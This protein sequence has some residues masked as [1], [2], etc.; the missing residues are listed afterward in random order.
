MD[1]MLLREVEYKY[2]QTSLGTWRSYLYPTGQLFREFQS[3]RRVYGFPLIHY[4]RGICPETGRHVITRG[5]IAVGRLAV[6]GIAIGHA[7]LG[8]VAIG[9]AAFGLAFGLGQL[10]T[11][12]FAI[13]QAAIG[14]VFG[15]GQFAT[16]FTAIGQF[17]IGKS[18]LGQVVVKLF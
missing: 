11:G 3:H 5:V 2:E 13:G 6:G 4:T 7:S 9:Q 1:N 15:L 16:G 8:V 17:A 14:L 12:A 10:A 18:V